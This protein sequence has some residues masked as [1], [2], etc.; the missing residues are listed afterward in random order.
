MAEI[1][2]SHGEHPAAEKAEGGRR[3]A[4]EKTAPAPPDFKAI[5]A[6]KP[7]P[8]LLSHQVIHPVFGLIDT[9]GVTGHETPEEIAAFEAAAWAR[10]GLPPL[11]EA[12]PTNAK[13]PVQTADK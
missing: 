10:A 8:L 1:F 5:F 3:K 6:P 2:I 13:P 4:E 9:I 11:D 12:V 7:G